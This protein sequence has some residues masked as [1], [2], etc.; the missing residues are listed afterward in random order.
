MQI[1]RYNCTLK[2]L[3]K[4][5]SHT[6]YRGFRNTDNK[7]VVVK[8][9][10]KKMLSSAEL[11]QLRHEH[12]VIASIES[13]GIINTYGLVNDEN[14]F[15]LLL[16]DFAGIDLA[17]LCLPANS[18]QLTDFFTIVRRTIQALEALHLQGITH[19]D[20]NPSNILF[21]STTKQIKIIDF[22]IA[23]SLAEETVRFGQ[24]NALE[25]TLAYIS[26]EQ[27]GRMNCAIDYRTDYYSLGV[28]FFQL[29]TGQLPFKAN[30]AL[31]IVH[32]HLTA[33]PPE[34]HTL[35]SD[36]PEMLSKILLKMM[37][38]NPDN[39]Y[40]STQGMLTDI[41]RCQAAVENNPQQGDK[42][43][44]LGSADQ[45]QKF[46]IPHKLYGRDVLLQRLTHEFELTCQGQ[47]RLL[48]VSGPSGIGKSSFIQELYRPITA[49]KGYFIGAKF[50]QYAAHAP[51]QIIG[52]SL[53]QLVKQLL[54][55][56]SAEMIQLKQTLTQRL[57]HNLPLL[58]SLCPE[59]SG[60]V[61]KQTT[62]NIS[63]AQEF[64]GRL[65]QTIYELL[66]VVMEQGQNTHSEIDSVDYSS[67][68]DFTTDSNRT[69]PIFIFFDDLQWAD[70]DFF[71][72][73]EDLLHK[74]E[75]L[76]LFFIGAYRDNEVSPAHPLSLTLT[77]LKA[78]DIA[79]SEITL[80]PLSEIHITEL[81]KESVGHDQ[82]GIDDLAKLVHQRTAGNPFFIRQFLLDLAQNKEIAFMQG[83]WQWDLAAITSHHVTHNVVQ[84]IL[85]KS[86]KLPLNSQQILM[87][88]A[89]IGSVFDFSLLKKVKQRIHNK[90]VFNGE[91]DNS[92]DDHEAMT[93]EDSIWHLIQSGFLIPLKTL[94]GPTELTTVKTT[95]V[96]FRFSHDKIHQAALMMHPG[97]V[98]HQ[99][100]FHI[101]ESLI[102]DNIASV[103]NK[104]VFDVVDHLN[105]SGA[106]L[107]NSKH[108]E[109]AQLNLRAAKLAQEQAAA[110]KSLAYVQSGLSLLSMDSAQSN[111]TSHQ[112]SINLSVI[113]AI[114]AFQCTQFSKVHQFSASVVELST[115]GLDKAIVKHIQGQVC[116]AEKNIPKTIEN[117]IAALAE[118]EII[119]PIDDNLDDCL[120]AIDQLLSSTTVAEIMSQSLCQSAYYNKAMEILGAIVLI[121]Y[122]TGSQDYHFYTK[123]LIQLSLQHGNTTGSTIGYI[124]YGVT[125]VSQGDYQY[126]V[127]MG[128]LALSLSHKINDKENL[129]LILN[130]ANY[131]LRHWQIHLHDLASPLLDSYRYASSIGSAFTAAVAAATANIAQFMAGD[132]LKM[133]VESMGNFSRI[134]IQFRQANIRNFIEPYRQFCINLTSDCDNPTHLIGEAYNEK[135]SLP[136]LISTNDSPAGV[137]YYYCKTLACYLFEDFQAAY[138]AAQAHTKHQ[139]IIISTFMAPPMLWIGSLAHLAVYNRCDKNEQ[140]E[141]LQVVG[142]NQQR[143]EQWRKHCAT[144]YDHKYYLIE[145]EIARIS[146]NKADAGRHYEKAI[147]LAERSGYLADEAL[148]NEVAGRFYLAQSDIKS[149]RFTFRTAY[150]CYLRWGAITKCK[151]LEQRYTRILP[152]M[153]R[154]GMNTATMTT[155]CAGSQDTNLLDV[156]GALQASQTICKEVSMDRLLVS[157]MN[158][159]VEIAGAESG[160]IT[161]ME[162][163]QS[164]VKVNITS[165]SAPAITVEQTIANVA[166]A[167]PFGLPETVLNYVTR[168]EQTLIL[169]NASEELPFSYDPYINKKQVKSVF[170]HPLVWQSQLTGLLYLENNQAEGL[171]ADRLIMLE[172]IAG[173]VIAS[174]ENARLQRELDNNTAT[175]DTS[176]NE[177]NQLQSIQQFLSNKK[178]TG[179][180]PSEVSTLLDSINNLIDG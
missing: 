156:I 51:Y 43:F 27:T 129:A 105:Q 13:T 47:A 26:P 64:Q 147:H 22:G 60:I 57:K 93:L 121:M 61:G 116:Q 80:T 115:N 83:Q 118:M 50:D 148:I 46:Y 18:L 73:M 169:K 37:S 179:L 175:K 19:K 21:N 11:A 81:I 150:H 158:V 120:L 17:S 136:I 56:K 7:A 117:Y 5:G 78:A 159:L 114:T 163:E 171:F 2:I 173:Q 166:A 141:I 75:Y 59:F 178:S 1:T 112:V 79:V 155:I 94:H 167:S 32:A 92:A 3:K 145:A 128:D 70:G 72:F 82:H 123:H 62:E 152:G 65:H 157:L 25:G 133:L 89:C 54:T 40:Q 132:E 90:Q 84:L 71:K 8:A 180:A 85:Q 140:Q 126:G 86:Q 33:P 138:T 101:A 130:Y 139:S 4:S 31:E 160:F 98:R 104:D 144:N 174:L 58:V 39:R 74:C 42:H 77:E 24:V 9:L 103:D 109:Y 142:E 162:G 164:I 10:E 99:I 146:N 91:V 172:L 168:T 12:H 35:R 14:R 97:S 87:S 170:C 67:S 20:I 95:P 66:A 122:F 48:T 161:M 137:N 53:Q 108:L 30:D 102:T 44:D 131:L 107:N 41:E 125:K 52:Q 151:Q 63:T 177:D 28:T 16:E 23:T 110:S 113:G 38:K 134:I 88:A 96:L 29:L 153:L 111:E 69:K 149:A 165:P 49:K 154:Q 119:I 106:L 76:P 45:R 68:A 127:V 15:G 135:I 34:V 36:V 100:H 176:E 55:I 143:F 124:F 6:I